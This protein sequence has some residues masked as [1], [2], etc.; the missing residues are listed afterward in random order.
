M[1]KGRFNL[2]TL[3]KVQKGIMI[4]SS[5]LILI[6]LFLSVCL[7]YVFKI[8]LFGIE[9]LLLIPIFLLYF[10]GA[11]QG[12]YEKSHITADILESYVKS[13]KIKAWNRLVTSVVVLIVCL[14]ITFWNS[15]YIFWSFNNGGN[16]SGYQIPL[17]IPHGTVL[18]GFIL[19]SFY[20]LIDFFRQISM[21]KDEMKKGKE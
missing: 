2:K 4:I 16:T 12:S 7:R 15:Q 19:M 10:I 1:V 13:G 8:D 14:I 20:S 3:V 9:E 18:I 6:G 17:F 5:I 11:A 21:V